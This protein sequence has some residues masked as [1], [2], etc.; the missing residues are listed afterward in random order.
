MN[1][2]AG[3]GNNLQPVGLGGAGRDRALNGPLGLVAPLASG[4]GPP[5]A[6][7]GLYRTG[8]P[9]PARSAPHFIGA[10]LIASSAGLIGCVAA[11]MV[12]TSLLQSFAVYSLTGMIVFVFLLIV[13]TGLQPAR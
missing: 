5:G 6:F 10:L 12:E 2:Q 3:M 11:L 8:A 1:G 13:Q 7:A 4:V 9:D